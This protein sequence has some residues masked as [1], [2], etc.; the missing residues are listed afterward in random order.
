MSHPPN[1]KPSTA[2]YSTAVQNDLKIEINLANTEWHDKEPLWV[3]VVIHNGTSSEVRGLTAFELVPLAK[4]T[5]AK[6]DYNT[7]WAP[8]NLAF[9]ATPDTKTDPVVVV[10]SGRELKGKLDLSKLKWGRQVQ[11]VWPNQNLFQLITSGSYQLTLE[12]QQESPKGVKRHKS[13]AV[14]VKF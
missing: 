13:P 5:Q 14:T 7:L 8:T 9:D 10:E 4:M 3:D 6:T 11:S 12:V 1:Q 2:S